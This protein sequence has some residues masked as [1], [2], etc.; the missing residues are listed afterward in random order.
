MDNETALK[1]IG[2]YVLKDIDPKL[3]ELLRKYVESAVLKHRHHRQTELEWNSIYDD[4]LNYFETVNGL[5]GVR[6]QK[7]LTKGLASKAVDKS[8]AKQDLDNPPA[9]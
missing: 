7:S 1:T 5:Y 3:I 6:L 8:T 2:I 9:G 4:V